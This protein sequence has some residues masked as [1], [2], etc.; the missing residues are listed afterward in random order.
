MQEL[1]GQQMEDGSFKVFSY[2]S[3]ALQASEKNYSTYLLELSAMVFGVESNFAY[4]HGH[5]FVVRTDHQ[6]A[7][8]IKLSNV[9]MRT[10]HRFWDDIPLFW[11]TRNVRII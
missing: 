11:S 3:R 7:T 10:L 5:F 2:R 1:L 6:P 8:K 4:L 9:H